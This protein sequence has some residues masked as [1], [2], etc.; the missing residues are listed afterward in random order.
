M[1]PP[2]HMPCPECGASVARH[3]TADHVCEPDRLLDYA[4]FQLRDEIARFEDDL[5]SYL[6]SAR[7][8]FELWYAA[9]QRGTSPH[10]RPRES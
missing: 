2:S 4:L 10:P 6:N 9:R 1:F 5:R 3:T 7:G 8:R